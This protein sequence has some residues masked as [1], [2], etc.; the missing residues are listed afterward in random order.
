M[1]LSRG[2]PRGAEPCFLIPLCNSSAASSAGLSGRA[3]GS[4]QNTIRIH[5]SLPSIFLHGF[6]WQCRTCAANWTGELFT[7]L[8]S[9]FVFTVDTCS[10]AN[11]LSLPGTPTTRAWTVDRAVRQPLRV[12]PRVCP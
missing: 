12:L 8:P 1:L 6:A 10:G 4:R 2:G 9:Q 7:T 3:T 5:P 11:P